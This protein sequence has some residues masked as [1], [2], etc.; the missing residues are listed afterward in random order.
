MC[1][2]W[3]PEYV[4]LNERVGPTEPQR[5]CTLFPAPKIGTTTV[6]VRRRRGGPQ[7]EASVA[8][9]SPAV[10]GELV[11][12]WTEFHQPDVAP[13]VAEH[14]DDLVGRGNRRGAWKIRGHQHFS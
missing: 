2:R 10:A 14:E 6:H 9:G 11:R 12:M 5:I 8:H 4:P 7:R 1:T 13:E 3:E